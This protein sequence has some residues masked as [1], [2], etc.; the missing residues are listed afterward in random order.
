MEGR[1]REGMAGMGF[2]SRNRNCQDLMM[3]MTDMMDMME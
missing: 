2:I 1:T 3:D